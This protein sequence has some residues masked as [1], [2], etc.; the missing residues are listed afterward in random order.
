MKKILKMFL[1]S[2]LLACMLFIAICFEDFK[3]RMGIIIFM[4]SF[5]FFVYFMKWGKSNERKKKE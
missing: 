3:V 4:Y 1:L 5:S 2:V